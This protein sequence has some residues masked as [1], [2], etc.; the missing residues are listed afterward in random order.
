MSEPQLAVI[1]FVFDLYWILLGIAQNQHTQ[2]NFQ[3]QISTN[4][5]AAVI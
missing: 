5:K 3:Q 1:Y 4:G 2:I